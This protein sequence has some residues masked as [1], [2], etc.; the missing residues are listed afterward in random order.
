MEGQ[1]DSL[2]KEEVQFN[3]PLRWIVGLMVYAD[4]EY[5]HI[6]TFSDFFEET[7]EN[8]TYKNTLPYGRFMMICCIVLSW[9]KP[10]T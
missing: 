2:M 9:K 1:F 7:M 3:N 4:E 6:Y 5:Y 8:L 10:E